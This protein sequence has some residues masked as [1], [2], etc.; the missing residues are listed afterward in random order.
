VGRTD[1]AGR[2]ARLNNHLE[3]A[4]MPSLP[5][6]SWNFSIDDYA[7][8][9]QGLHIIDL[10][11]SYDYRPGIGASNPYEY[12]NFLPV[13]AYIKDYLANYPNETDFWE[14]VNRKLVESTLTDPL[15]TPY[16]TDYHLGDVIDNL[17]ITLTVHADSSIPYTR[18]STVTQ[19]VLVGDQKAN[20]LDGGFYG[21][22]V[23]GG[24]GNDWLR[25]FAGDD[26]L[27]GG[28]GNDHIE[29]GI[30]AD[31]IVGGV[32]SDWLR[33][34]AGADIFQFRSLEELSGRDHILDFMHPQGDKIDLSGLD[35]KAG[36]VA[37]DSFTLVNAFH[38]IAGELVA[39]PKGD[40]KVLVEGDVSG[41]GKAD[42]IISVNTKV[43]L[44][45]HD[46]V[47]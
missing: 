46:F 3:G 13:A 22:A 45:S 19:S 42:F 7:I 8:A 11:V 39:L 44:S 21:D 28:A 9:H 4:T 26:Y 36:S 20:Q 32:G 33:G 15:P 27:N 2:Y 35:A 17:S 6:E 18:S 37:N 31:L 14:I 40:N 23:R 34:G 12:P 16:G 10:D 5:E 24:A 43:P 29:G 41:T 30:G 1:D 47:L 38:G 25:G